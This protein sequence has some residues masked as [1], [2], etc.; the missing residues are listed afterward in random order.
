MHC[1]AGAKQREEIYE[2][3]EKIY[4][5]LQEFRK[6]D[7][8]AVLPPA[9]SPVQQ[10]LSLWCCMSQEHQTAQLT[11]Q[12]IMQPHSLDIAMQPPPPSL[13]APAPQLI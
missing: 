5:T 12:S 9:P 6:G 10:V 2:A 11:F 3:F 7:A 1:R 4:P 13:G 8:A